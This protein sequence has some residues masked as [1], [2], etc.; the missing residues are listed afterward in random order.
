MSSRRWLWGLYTA[1]HA[2]ALLWPAAAEACATCD[3]GDPT[4]TAAG[5]EQPFAGRRR[6][7]LELRYRT[8]ALGRPGIDRANIREMAA[9]VSMAWAPR[10]DLF[11]IVDVPLLYRRVEDVNLARS[12]TWSLGELA[13]SAKWFVFRD[14][15]FAPRWLVAL[16]GG[17]KLPTAPW[18]EDSRGNYLP[19][20]AQPGSGSLDVGLG[21][22][23]AGFLGALSAYVSVQ[24]IEPVLKREPLAP[25]SSLRASA[26]L[27]YQVRDPLAVRI[28]V[29]L[30]WDRQSEEAGQPDPDSGGLVAFPGADLLLSPLLDV[31]AVLG[32]RFPLVSRLNGAHSE[33]AIYSVALVYDW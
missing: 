14:R 9:D 32:C 13:L 7:A 22:S 31:T 15:A 29:D 4:L 21:P 25:G 5:T 20:E 28:A 12:E 6:S 3:S 26:A 33:G 16:I 11:L 8:D 30:R 23:L 27:Q 18:R 2:L 19:L 1:L 17:V 10:D 24:W